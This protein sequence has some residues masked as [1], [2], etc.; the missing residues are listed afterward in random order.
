M[1][2]QQNVPRTLQYRIDKSA[3]ELREA[4]EMFSPLI[5]NEGSVMRL[6]LKPTFFDPFSP[7]GIVQISLFEDSKNKFTEVQVTV[8]PITTTSNGLYFLLFLL[9]IWTAFILV[10]FASVSSVIMILMGWTIGFA[11]IYFARV[12]NLGKLENYVSLLVQQASRR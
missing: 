5:K 6:F 2:L 9:V 3:D 10:W 12:L 8:I 7:R 11:V 4:I 1:R